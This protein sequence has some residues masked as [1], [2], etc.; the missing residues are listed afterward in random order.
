MQEMSSAIMFSFVLIHCELMPSGKLIN[1][2]Q[3][4]RASK[5]PILERLH[6]WM[7]QFDVE[8]LSVMLRRTG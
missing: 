4:K 6:V 3:K 8:I 7:V 2:E 1:S 5:Q